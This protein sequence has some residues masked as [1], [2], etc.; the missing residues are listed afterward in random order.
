MEPWR[1]QAAESVVGVGEDVRFISGGSIGNAPAVWEKG[2]LE[3]Q[4]VPRGRVN[5]EGIETCGGGGA[6]LGG[7]GG[8][9]GG[10]A[11]GLW[12]GGEVI[13]EAESCRLT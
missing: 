8:G 9:L 3:P 5:S 2:E 4:A 11:I 10:L 12:K 1:P 13:E 6:W 7:G